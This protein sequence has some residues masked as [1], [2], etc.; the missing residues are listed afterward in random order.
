M[1]PLVYPNH[2]SKRHVDSRS[3]KPRCLQDTGYTIMTNRQ[4]DRQTDGRGYKTCTVSIAA[5]ATGLA[6][7]A[8][9]LILTSV[10]LFS[11]IFCNCSLSTGLGNCTRLYVDKG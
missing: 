3:P 11:A 7:A 6:D 2:H 4:T 5:I 8:M 1:I 9:Q 10:C